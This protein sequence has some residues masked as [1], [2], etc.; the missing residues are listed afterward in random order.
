MLANVRAFRAGVPAAA[1][2]GPSNAAKVQWRL[3][4]VLVANAV[5][6]AGSFSIEDA[7]APWRMRMDATTPGWCFGLGGASVVG[8]VMALAVEG[9]S[10]AVAE[11]LLAATL[12]GYAYF[13]AGAAFIDPRR[14]LQLAHLVF[15]GVELG[16]VCM[17]AMTLGIAI[18]LMFRQRLRFGAAPARHAGTQYQL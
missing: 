15:R 7:L 2:G 8:L 1:A 14:G 13:L 4:I 16:L 5:L 9:G 6:I 10:L 18:R 11:S 12:L 3:A 17:A